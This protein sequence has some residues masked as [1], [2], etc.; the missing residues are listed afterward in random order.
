MAKHFL[1]FIAICCFV[2]VSSPT[3]AAPAATQPQREAESLHTPKMLKR[4]FVEADA[5]A[6]NQPVD[7]K[8][9]LQMGLSKR[10]SAR[11][12][13]ASSPIMAVAT[14]F[15]A[16]IFVVGIFMLIAWFMKRGVSRGMQALP[17]EVF[18]ILGR[19]TLGTQ[20]T[21][22]LVRV[23]NKLLLVA[24]SA[25]GATT[26]TEIVDTAEVERLSALCMT[27]SETSTTQE[28]H[29]TF[30]ELAAGSA[31]KPSASKPS[32]G[33]ANK[34]R[35]ESP[36]VLDLSTPSSDSLTLSGASLLAPAS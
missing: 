18:E 32:T 27:G 6:K 20:Q 21:I 24:S 28:F 15:A 17:T 35:S 14:S 3:L 25:D 33:K 22:Q 10:K 23:G 31:S 11:T 8:N 16:L 34:Y 2:V 19:S 1:T 12:P 5:K 13:K 26:L 9:I 7:S 4:I 30:E 36:T 29:E